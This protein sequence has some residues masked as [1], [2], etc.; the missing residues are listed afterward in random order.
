MPWFA[1]IRMTLRTGFR[2]RPPVHA[3]LRTA[4]R[5]TFRAPTRGNTLHDGNCAALITVFH[6]VQAT[7]MIQDVSLHPFRALCTN[8]QQASHGHLDRLYASCMFNPPYLPHFILATVHRLAF[9]SFS[10]R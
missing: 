8:G 3:L 4:D 2:N 7:A 6:M 5:G 1:S 9:I 10:P